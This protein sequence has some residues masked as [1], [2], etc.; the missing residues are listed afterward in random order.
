[1]TVRRVLVIRLSSLGDVVLTAPVLAALKAAWPGCHLTF[2]TKGAFAPVFSH[3]PHV[4]KVLQFE[5]KGLWGWAREIRQSRFDVIIDLHDTFRSRVWSF[6]SGAPRTVRYDKRAADRRRLVWTKRVSPRLSGGVVDRYLETL[7]VLGISSA[8]RVPQLFLGPEER[9]PD[10]LEKRLGPGPFVAIA[11]GALHPTKRWGPDRFAEAADRLAEGKPVILLGAPAD[12]PAAE[13]VLQ[14]LTSSAQSFVGQTSVR[15]MMLI[16]RRCALLLTNDSG[17]MH[18]A[19]A[20]GVPTVAIFGPTVKPFGFFP[21]GAW[22][23]AIEAANLDCRPCSVHGSKTCPL[24]HFRC[25]KEVTVDQVVK[26]A[27]TLL[28]SPLRGLS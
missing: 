23:S 6:L 16:L 28:V 10:H 20:L 5:D 2:L 4:N 17:A 25:M 27:Q 18:V 11:P 8:H 12:A 24:K 1:M 3:S 9:L 22:T 15:E 7:T 13:A 14:T 19:A 26:T 21:V